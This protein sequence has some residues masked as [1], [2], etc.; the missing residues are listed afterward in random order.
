MRR[1]AVFGDPKTNFV[2]QRIFGSEDHK[3]ALIGF[4]N[5]ILSAPPHR[6]QGQRRLSQGVQ[7]SPVYSPLPVPV[8][9]VNV[10]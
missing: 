2:F 6:R 8:A 9:A 7:I 1:T 5:D 3:T 4:L 10:P